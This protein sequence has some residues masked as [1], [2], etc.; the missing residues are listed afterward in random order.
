MI[1]GNAGMG[2]AVVMTGVGILQDW[3]IVSV[4]FVLVFIMF[5]ALTTGPVNWVYLSEILQPNAMSVA[6][7]FNWCFGI[8]AA[9]SLPEDY[10]NTGWLF[11]G[12][13]GVTILGFLFV[14]FFMPE[15]KGKN[16]IEI[17]KLFYNVEK[18]YKE[19]VV[20]NMLLKDVES[21]H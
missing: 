8:A 6:I 5:F 12:T 7:F 1:I 11:V 21:E 14:I 2:I 9:A 3:G 4:I 13:G 16:S 17:E 15:T 19:K 18:E 10:K 20:N